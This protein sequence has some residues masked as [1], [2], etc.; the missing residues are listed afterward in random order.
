MDDL[1]FS[2]SH[3]IKTKDFFISSFNDTPQK[4]ILTILDL[5]GNITYVSPNVESIL[6]YPSHYFTGQNCKKLIHKEDWE[7]WI[8]HEKDTY[9]RYSFIQYRMVTMDGKEIWLESVFV[10]VPTKEGSQPFDEYVLLSRDISDRKRMEEALIANE[11]LAAVGKLAAGIAHDIRNPLTTIKGFLDLMISGTY[12][13]VY[14]E[15]MKTEV[16]RMNLITNELMLLAKPTKKEIVTFDIQQ[17]IRET[18]MLLDTEAFK[19]HVQFSTEFTEN[20]VIISGDPYQIK[21]ALINI[22]KNAIE[23]IPLK[24]FIYI[25]VRHT[26][27]VC[28]IEIEDEGCGVSKEVINLLGKPFFTS[29]ETGNGLGL[30]MC[31]HIIQHHKGNINF[32]SQ[33]GHGTTVTIQLPLTT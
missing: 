9:K 33:E 13:P 8:D 21:Q 7:G 12:D 32:S 26:H 25:R 18:L 4:A 24:G 20:P 3:P 30:M 27:S 23:A 16:E 28:L 15:I 2:A 6:G 17:I 11:K 10:I 22:I 1:F 14:L 29:K 19:Q 5:K 31:H